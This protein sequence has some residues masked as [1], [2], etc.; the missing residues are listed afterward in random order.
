MRDALFQALRSHLNIEGLLHWLTCLRLISICHLSL[1]MSVIPENPRFAGYS[2]ISKI[3][4]SMTTGMV[5]LPSCSGG[6][7]SFPWGHSIPVAFSGGGCFLFSSPVRIQLELKLR[8]DIL[9]VP[10]RRSFFFYPLYNSE[11]HDNCFS[12]TSTYLWFLFLGSPSLSLT[13]CHYWKRWNLQY[14][15]DLC[16][17]VLFSTLPPA[18]L[19]KD[20]SLLSHS[21][22]SS[23]CL[24]TP[25]WYHFITGNAIVLY[26]VCF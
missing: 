26:Y 14:F 13:L 5:P 25:S 18:S 22:F 20:F 21:V 4:I 10:Y 11:F 24:P 8:A 9:F 17:N 1:F 23:L 12:L 3:L 2:I 16:S 7:W 6:N 15:F 19:S